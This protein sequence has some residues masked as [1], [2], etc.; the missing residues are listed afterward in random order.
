MIFGVRYGWKQGPSGL[1]FLG[2]G[3]GV[4]LSIPTVALRNSY[5]HC[6]P[7]ATNSQSR[8]PKIRCQCPDIHTP[9]SPEDRLSLAIAASILAPASIL[10]FS[11]SQFSDVH[12]LIPVASGVPYCTMTS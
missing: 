3:L 4:C 9:R 2:M 1:A 8:V 11:W 10:W 12:W 5:Y 6:K 7:I